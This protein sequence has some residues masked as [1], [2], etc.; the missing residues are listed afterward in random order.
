MV[1][2]GPFLQELMLDY[3]KKQQTLQQFIVRN[4]GEWLAVALFSVV[5]VVSTLCSVKGTRSLPVHWWQSCTAWPFLSEARGRVWGGS[6][7]LCGLSLISRSHL[8]TCFT[9]VKSKQNKK[10]H[11]NIFFRGLNRLDWTESL[12]FG[13]FF[14]QRKNGGNVSTGW[15]ESSPQPGP[16]PGSPSEE[17]SLPSP[18]RGTWACV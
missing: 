9:L 15:V 2:S 14:S 5:P 18:F 6:L 12:T 7:M 4:S 8:W 1:Q 17:E 3:R 16:E 10:S 11:W 13:P